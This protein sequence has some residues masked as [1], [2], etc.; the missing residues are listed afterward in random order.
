MLTKFNFLMIGIVTG[1]YIT[2]NYNVPKITKYIDETI[3]YFKKI[4]KDSRK[5]E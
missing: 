3:K 4:E 2:Q 5:E 1:I